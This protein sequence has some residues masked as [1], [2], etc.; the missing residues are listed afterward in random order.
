MKL[1]KSFSPLLEQV[2]HKDTPLSSSGEKVSA[3]IRCA[4]VEDLLLQVAELQ[5]TVKRLCSTRGAEMEANKWFQNHAPVADTTEN[6]AP[7]TPVTHKSR[8]LLQPPHPSIT[9]K[10]RSEALTAI[11]THEQHL[12]RETI[13]AA[14]SGYHK[15]KE[16]LIVGDSSICLSDRE[17]HN[18][19]YLPGGCHSLSRALSTI[20]CY[21]FMRGRMTPQARTWEES[22][23]ATKPWGC[24]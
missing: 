5:E 14:Y 12:Q 7:W 1:T 8:S 6:E 13:P 18:I 3:S 23:K 20:H 15:K 17:S 21:S 4:W 2:S 24:K 9:T 16:V 11:Y 22:R 19:C 10:T